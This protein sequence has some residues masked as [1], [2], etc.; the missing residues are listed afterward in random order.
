MYGGLDYR[1]N[2]EFDLYFNL[3]YALLDRGL[4]KR[5]ATIVFGIGADTSKARL[6]CNSAPLYVFG[7]GRGPLMSFIVRAAGSLLLAQKPAAPRFNMFRNKVVGNS[8]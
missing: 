1:L 6:G 5:G 3:L 2:R 7:K 4:Q 8:S